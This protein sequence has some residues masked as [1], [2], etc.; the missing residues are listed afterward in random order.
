[1]GIITVSAAIDEITGF[2]VQFV[3][4]RSTRGEAALL[5][6]QRGRLQPP[7]SGQRVG[8]GQPNRLAFVMGKKE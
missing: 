2:R 8:R 1:M 7:G 3:R 4:V 5:Q 6:R